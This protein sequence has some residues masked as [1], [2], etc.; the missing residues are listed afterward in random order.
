MALFWI[1]ACIAL[2][3]PAAVLDD[4]SAW[5][6]LR[7][8]WKLTKGSRGRIFVAWLMVFACALVLEGLAAFLVRWIAML[9]Y[10]GRHFAGFNL[11]VYTVVIYFFYAIVAAVVAPLYYITVSLIYYDQR[12][13]KEGYDVEIMMQAAGLGTGES[14]A[15]PLLGGGSP[16]FEETAEPLRTRV[17]K[18]IRS[19]RGFD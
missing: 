3:V 19:L 15:I 14:G 5:K 2:T 17:M 13:R 1:G 7:R 18:F 9:I 4:I 10:T 16:D 11:E 12:A 8:S 6:A